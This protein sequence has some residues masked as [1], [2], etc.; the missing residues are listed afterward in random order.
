MPCGCHGLTRRRLLT[1]GALAASG[2]ALSG[3]DRIELPNLVSQAQVERMG[4]QAWDDITA[5]TPTARGDPRARALDQVARRCIEAAGERPGDWEVR[6]FDVDQVN[7]FA[8]PGRKIGVY[9]GMFDVAQ[10]EA[11]LAAVIGH[12]IGHVQAEHAQERMSAEVAKSLGLRLVAIVLQ[13]GDVEFAE[14]IAAALGLGAQYGLILPYGR[15]QELEADR[16][17]L[18]VMA[19]AGYDP[20]AAVTLWQRMEQA[21]GGGPP[22]FLSTHPAPRSRI[23][24][25][26][27]MIP[28]IAL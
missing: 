28:R 27:E 3:C 20:G 2:A 7:A 6:L 8:L 1:G 5:A 4:L 11:Q 19:Q 13:L 15:A 12:E 17:G 23:E 10:D 9:A 24:E 16:L 14:G 26:R 22:A 18:R 25:I 21:S